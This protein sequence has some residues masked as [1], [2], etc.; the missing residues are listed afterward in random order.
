[1][2]FAS[3][4][5]TI[6]FL[7]LIK[8]QLI[9]GVDVLHEQFIVLLF[10]YFTSIDLTCFKLYVFFILLVFVVSLSIFAH[11]KLLEKKLE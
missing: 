3:N 6:D 10:Y 2:N 9:G 4:Q 5:V 7:V 11:I 1:M 8:N